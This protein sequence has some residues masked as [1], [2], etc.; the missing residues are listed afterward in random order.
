MFGPSEVA[1][2]IEEAEHPVMIVA[3]TTPVGKLEVIGSFTQVGRMLYVSN[4][5]VQGLSPGKLGG[6]G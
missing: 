5:H 6:L 4:A 1:I 2:E 3:I